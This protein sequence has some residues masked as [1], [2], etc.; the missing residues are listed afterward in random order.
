MG[1]DL[2]AP[3]TN[4]LALTEAL[5]DGVYGPL[6]PAQ[7]ETLK[8][9]RDNGH[10]MINMVT[11]LVDLARFETGQLKLEPAAAEIMEPC[12]LGLEMARGQAKAK[13]VTI[14]SEFIPPAV[15]ATAD[16]RRLRQL[17][18]ALASAAVVSAPADGQVSFRVEARPAEGRLHIRIRT[19]RRSDQSSPQDKSTP[20]G[21]A[22]GAALQRLRKL[23]SVAVTMAEKIIE[24][25]AG[26]LEAIDRGSSGFSIDAMLPLVLPSH[27][28]MKNAES[29]ESG[30]AG[31]AATTLPLILLADDEEIIRTITKD[32]LESTG[33]YRVACVTNG[34]E[35]LDYVQAQAP[36]LLIMDM[37]MP[38]LDG[39]DALVQL[40]QSS[41][42]R[43]A[44]TPVI[45][46][47]GLATPGHRERSLAAG[48]DDCLAKPFGIK[49]LERVIKETLAKRG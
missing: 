11:D 39:M 49:E 34:R 48:A 40:R 20:E 27:A 44:R 32:Y 17:A 13:K 21:I 37:Q 28:Q 45:S 15:T 31:A 6:A 47:S 43:I 41:D 24:L 10:R 35:A 25:H 9:I 29:Q 7:S 4:I 18:S 22:T 23:S 3:M 8:H 14:D 36:D 26:T 12:R 38:V 16:A 33:S 1:H 19:A 42:P 30:A 2:R 46:L 5:V